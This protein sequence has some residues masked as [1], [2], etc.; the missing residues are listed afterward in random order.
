LY[1]IFDKRLHEDKEIPV[2]NSKFQAPNSKQALNP[3]TEI[4][5]CFVFWDLNIRICLLPGIWSLEILSNV[6]WW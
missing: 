5:N 1:D 4:Q 3:K 6:S 2:T